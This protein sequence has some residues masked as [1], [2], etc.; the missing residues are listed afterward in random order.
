MDGL[1]TLF[2]GTRL[3]TLQGTR[4]S[5]VRVLKILES[6]DGYRLFLFPPPFKDLSGPIILTTTYLQ[7]SCIR[8]CLPTIISTP[9]D[10]PA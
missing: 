4:I 8:A 7:I 3:H 5:Q 2:V 9:V 1:G 10:I 6:T